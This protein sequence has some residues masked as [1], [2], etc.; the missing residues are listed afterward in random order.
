MSKLNYVRIRQRNLQ[1]VP[2]LHCDREVQEVQWVQ[3]DRSCHPYQGNQKIQKV[4]KEQKH[5]FPTHL[6]FSLKLRL[7]L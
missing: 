3:A 2:S 6:I 1:Q 4:P 5:Q 7:I